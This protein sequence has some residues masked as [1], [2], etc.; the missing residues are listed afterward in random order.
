MFFFCS[1]KCNKL[2]KAKKNPRKLKWTKAYRAAHGKELINDPVLEFEK[3]RNVPTR[4]N[5]DL[6][7][8]TIQAM[9]RVDEIKAARKQRHFDKRMDAH[10]QKK[11]QDAENELMKHVDLISDPAIKDYIRK[12]KEQKLK[13][14]AERQ[15]GG[16]AKKK[17]MALDS[18]DDEDMDVESESEE[19]EVQVKQKA[20]AKV[21]VGKKAGIKKK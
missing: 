16:I 4:Y 7:V 12:K 11:K 5:R 9:K 18:S 19:E 10:K 14:K 13:S 8:K 1:S 21:K 17:A 20:L 2:F 3:R 6:M 15:S